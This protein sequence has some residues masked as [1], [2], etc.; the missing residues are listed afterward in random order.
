MCNRSTGGTW[1]IKDIGYYEKGVHACIVSLRAGKRASCAGQ[2]YSQWFLFARRF[3]VPDLDSL[4][5]NKY[6]I[7]TG[8]IVFP[9]FFFWIKM[10]GNSETHQIKAGQLLYTVGWQNSQ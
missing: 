8:K 4:K 6:K 10:G 2:L 5:S 1:F 9:L 3:T 7:T